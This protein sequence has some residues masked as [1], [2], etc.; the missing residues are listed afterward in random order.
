[1]GTRAFAW[2]MSAAFLWSLACV[3]YL[4]DDHCSLN[5]AD[6][7]AGLICSWCDHDNLGCV[8]P[9]I[10]LECI[11][12]PYGDGSTT[13]PTTEATTTESTTGSTSD[14]TAST[15]MPT[16]ST[17]GEPETTSE[18]PLTTEDPTTGPETCGDGEVQPGE[19]C[20]DG[21]DDNNDACLNSCQ[22][23]TCG[24]GVVWQGNESCDDGNQNNE[25]N[26][27]TTCE[28]ASCGD[29]FV[30]TG[31]EECDDQ[32]EDD[33]DGCFQCWRDR[34]V[35]ITSQDFKGDL[36]GLTGADEKCQTA[37]EAAE[38]GGTFQAWLSAGD[39]MPLTRMV[40]S[41]GI[42]KRVDGVVLARGWND[43]TDGLIDA[44]IS[45]DEH[46]EPLTTGSWTNTEASGLI[47]A[48]PADCDGWTNDEFEQK[49]RWGTAQSIEPAWSNFINDVVNPQVC[50]ANR[51]LYCVMQEVEK[52]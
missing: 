43:L 33:N 12:P 24:D 6:C 34:L 52:P 51:S 15:E 21:N 35:F 42:Y 13:E 20:D 49:G 25:D 36:G 17:T 32:N 7:E 5:G 18:N 38:L 41:A 29:G 3:P 9:D 39:D 23:A 14:T 28:W 10:A 22:E 30:Q 47:A 27:L 40:H 46:G 44:T 26:C 1:M 2:G 4:S 16:E 31:E 37:A 11:V 8:L 45:I 50:N 19:G 48:D